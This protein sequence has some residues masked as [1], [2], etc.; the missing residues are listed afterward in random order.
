MTK[1]QLGAKNLNEE[2]S[3]AISRDIIFRAGASG[4][5]SLLKLGTAPLHH[6]ETLANKGFYFL[7]RNLEGNREWLIHHKHPQHRIR[8]WAN[9]QW[10]LSGIF[11][12]GKMNQIIR[13][14]LETRQPID[15]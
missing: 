13:I 8:R 9:P 2:E 6:G 5:K 12:P 14:F 7:L 4:Q 15:D 3:E 10:G 11:L 1:G